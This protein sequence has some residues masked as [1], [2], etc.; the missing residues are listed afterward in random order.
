MKGVAGRNA[1]IEPRLNGIHGELA[2]TTPSAPQ[3][4]QA[5]RPGCLPIRFD[6]DIILHRQNAPNS[7]FWKIL[8][9]R[10]RALRGHGGKLTG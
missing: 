10:R 1:G 5:A 6:I 8:F 7:T 3:A 4:A 9:T 2:R